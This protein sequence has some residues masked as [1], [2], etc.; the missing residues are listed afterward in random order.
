MKTQFVVLAVLIAACFSQPV[1][2][3][4]SVVLLSAPARVTRMQF[5]PQGGGAVHARICG[6]TAQA[7][8]G[9][10]VESCF[11]AILPNGNAI[12]TSVTNLATGGALTFWK[13]QENL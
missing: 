11:D 13:Q 7:D 1:L 3:D 12:A 6:T 10:P 8:G 2:A 9:V 5:T 4:R